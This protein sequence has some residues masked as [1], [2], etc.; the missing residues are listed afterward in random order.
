MTEEIGRPGCSKKF[1]VSAGSGSVIVNA[2]SYGHNGAE[3]VFYADGEPPEMVASIPDR[4]VY[5]VT[6]VS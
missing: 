1:K 2:D 3:Y 6:E 5:H 4:H